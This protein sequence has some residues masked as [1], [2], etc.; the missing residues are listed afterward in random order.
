VYSSINEIHA[1]Q[2]ELGR[3]K[4][5]L[6]KELSY[7]KGSTST[8]RKRMDS[9]REQI[10]SKTKE[11]DLQMNE[12]KQVLEELEEVRKSGKILQE[13]QNQLE[14]FLLIQEQNYKK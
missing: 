9:L 12:A 10:K 3:A 14:S 2:K 6:A 8:L 11:R 13:E 4:E 1:K 7:G 5:D